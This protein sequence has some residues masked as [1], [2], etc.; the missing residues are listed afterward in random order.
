MHLHETAFVVFFNHLSEKMNKR[1][2]NAAVLCIS[3]WLFIEY[4]AYIVS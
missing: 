3:T 4:I 1:V 2:Q